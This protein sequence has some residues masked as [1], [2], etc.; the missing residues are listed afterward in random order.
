MPRRSVYE[1]NKNN[2]IN[3]RHSNYT[4]LDMNELDKP[5]GRTRAMHFALGMFFWFIGAIISAIA[6][7]EH[8]KRYRHS[9]MLHALLG[10]ACGIVLCAL[11]FALVIAC[12]GL[13]P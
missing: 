8:G 13:L 3:G 2:A 6:T 12:S 10:T 4:L 11:A 9:C 7:R 1:I 5:D